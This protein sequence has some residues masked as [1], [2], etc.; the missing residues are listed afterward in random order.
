MILI[1][2][3]DKFNVSKFVKNLISSNIFNKL[4]C[5]KFKYFKLIKLFNCF[6]LGVII[7]LLLD[8]SNVSKFVNRNVLFGIHDNFLLLIDSFFISV[9]NLDRKSVV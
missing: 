6:K 8:K 2:F 7:I 9:D 1:S 5:D 4:F 3:L